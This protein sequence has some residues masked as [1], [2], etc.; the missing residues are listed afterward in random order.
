MSNPPPPPGDKPQVRRILRG[1][2]AGLSTADRNANDKVIIADK[3]IPVVVDAD[4][5]EL[6]H[7]AKGIC[8]LTLG[9]AT[10]WIDAAEFGDYPVIGPDSP[11]EKFKRLVP[12]EQR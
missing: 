11:I 6:P 4:A 5:D 12:E 10:Q 3:V 9:G 2:L 8:F 1:R 7:A